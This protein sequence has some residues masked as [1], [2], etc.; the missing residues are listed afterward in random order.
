MLASIEKLITDRAEQIRARF[1]A[2][3]NKTK[4]E[5]PAPRHKSAS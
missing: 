2:L 1:Q 4:R 3:L 5:S